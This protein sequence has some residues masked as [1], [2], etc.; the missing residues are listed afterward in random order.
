MRDCEDHALQQSKI[1]DDGTVQVDLNFLVDLILI[2]KQDNHKRIL[3]PPQLSLHK[4]IL[5]TTHN[6]RQRFKPE[7]IH[8]KFKPKPPLAKHS[9]KLPAAVEKRTIPVALIHQG[10]NEVGTTSGKELDF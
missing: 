3:K 9:T 7:N 4:D 8:E 5:L 1:D 10:I 6:Q 2:L